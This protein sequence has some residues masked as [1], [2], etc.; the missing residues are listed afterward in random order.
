MK[1]FT[2]Y[3]RINLLATVIVFV[4][5]GIAFYFLLQYVLITQV[6]EDLKIEQ[7]EIEIYADKYRHLPEIIAVKDQH[8]SYSAID[9]GDR[10]RTFRTAWMTDGNKKEKELFR[11]LSFSVR[12]D[13]QWYRATVSKSLEGTDDMLQ[14][15]ASITFITILVML[16]VS[17][18]INRIV[19]KKLWQ[20]FYDALIAMKS[21]ELGKKGQPHFPATTIDEFN[22]MNDTLKQATE[23]AYQDYQNLK[24]FTENASHELQTPVAIIRSKLDVLIQDEHL[25]ESQSTTV[26]AAYEAVQRLSRL[27]QGLL[28]LTKIENGQYNELA[29]IDLSRKIKEKITQFEEIFELKQISITKKLDENLSFSMNAELAEI[30]FNNLFSNA[31]KYNFKGG[32][33]TILLK[34]GCL[35]ISN[36]GPATALDNTKVF[37]RFGNAGQA[38]DGI[39]LG[40]AI[41]EQV[42]A[43]SGLTAH[44]QYYD[45]RHHFQLKN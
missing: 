23:K 36:T 24:E 41:I 25:S 22:V 43:F 35:E 20:P 45:Q 1:L 13:D 30:L 29:S 26:Q 4:L 38:G 3:S 44:Y 19:L 6:D 33:I 17:L 28:L 5:S 8:I 10:K 16:T 32:N 21:F 42:A 39:G 34:K 18:L 40:L 12:T 9:K 27:N 31:I 14:S 7:N 37:R 15:I 2:R 11:Q